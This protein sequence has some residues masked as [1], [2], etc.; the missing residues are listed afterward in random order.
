MGAISSSAGLLIQYLPTAAATAAFPVLGRE[1][2]P[3]VGCLGGS[4]WSYSSK[5]SKDSGSTHPLDQIYLSSN[6]LEWI[7]CLIQEM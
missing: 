4:A 2:G 6:S 7:L 1:H 3:R 5:L